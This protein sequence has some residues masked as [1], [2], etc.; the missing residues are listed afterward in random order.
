M[1]VCQKS[2]P[3]KATTIMRRIR[4]RV[5]RLKV[6]GPLANAGGHI[7]DGVANWSKRPFAD[8]A[9]G[10]S[11]KILHRIGSGE[12]AQT[13]SGKRRQHHHEQRWGLPGDEE[14]EPY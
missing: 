9:H 13:H 11:S 5:S 12:E 4:P 10:A 1:T 7:P 14:N 3:R 2:A 8:L 6:L